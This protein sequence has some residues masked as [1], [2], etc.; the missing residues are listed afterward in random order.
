[1]HFLVTETT[2]EKVQENLFILKHGK[3]L[4]V[5]IAVER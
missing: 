3:L 4:N 5:L 2:C 1:M